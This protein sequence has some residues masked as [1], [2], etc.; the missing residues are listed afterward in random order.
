MTPSG[1]M[2]SRCRSSGFSDARDAW[3]RDAHLGHPAAG[4]VRSAWWRNAP[5]TEQ[6]A[7]DELPFC[8]SSVCGRDA[9]NGRTGRG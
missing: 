6:Y 9:Q 2:R 1:T 7:R 5:Y 3:G 4:S 8:A